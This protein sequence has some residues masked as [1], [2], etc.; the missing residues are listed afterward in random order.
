MSEYAMTIGDN[1]WQVGIWFVG[2]I[3][4]RYIQTNNINVPISI[5]NI[6]Y[7]Y[8]KFLDVNGRLSHL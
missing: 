5:Y 8:R 7:H 6:L 3:K 1:D 4:E 2:G